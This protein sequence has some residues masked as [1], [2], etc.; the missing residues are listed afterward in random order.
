MAQA[1]KLS[2]RS[3]LEHLAMKEVGTGHPEITQFEW[4]TNIH[5][6]SCASYIGH[7]PILSY[8]AAADGMSQERMRCEM[9]RRMVRPCGMRPRNL[10]DAEEDEDEEMADEQV[11][12]SK[13]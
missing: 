12:E 10:L 13:Q 6:D 1:E 2:V 3:Q 8:M 5:R 9:F 7:V 4:V 11:G